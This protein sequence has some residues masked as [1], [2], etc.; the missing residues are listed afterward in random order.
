MAGQKQ[1]K[2]NSAVEAFILLSD[3]LSVEYILLTV[4]F[5]KKLA[6]EVDMNLNKLASGAHAIGVLLIAAV[7]ILYEFKRTRTLHIYRF[8]ELVILTYALLDVALCCII[9][10]MVHENWHQMAPDVDS[11]SELESFHQEQPQSQSEGENEPGSD[12]ATFSQKFYIETKALSYSVSDFN[13][14][15][16]KDLQVFS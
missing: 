4:Y 1:S 2:T 7:E 11:D 13:L 3:I 10:L 15:E 12:F 9:C 14:T 5:A 8:E 6:H 16:C